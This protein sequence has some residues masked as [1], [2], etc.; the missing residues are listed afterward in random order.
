MFCLALAALERA[1]RQ[2]ALGRLAEDVETL[3]ASDPE[4]LAVGIEFDIED[5]AS[6]RDLVHVARFLAELHV[7]SRVHGD[8]QDYLHE[9]GARDVLYNIHPAAL[10]AVLN[11][12][13]GPST[14]KDG[15][16]EE[17]I[18]RIVEEPRPDTAEARNRHLRSTVVRRLLDD[19]VLYYEDLCPEELAYLRSQRPLLVKE[20]HEATGL[21]PE[22]RL[23][24]LALVDEGG[25]MTDVALPDAGTDGH[26]TLLLVEFLAE[27]ARRDPEGVV[28]RNTIEHRTAMLIS[29]HRKHWRK[30]VAMPGAETVLAAQTIDRLAALGL[31][32][33]TEDGVRPSPAIARY[34]VRTDPRLAGTVKEKES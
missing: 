4:L 22:V 12:R 2:T 27:H 30:D 1:D 21:H 8:E 24:G 7:L 25:D 15:R 34:S 17:R 14:V 16:L 23:E 3:V 29:E 11:V 13:R 18:S 19:P 31:V 20:I 28:G 32:R 6:R 5:Y 9:T 33:R 26:L 10:A